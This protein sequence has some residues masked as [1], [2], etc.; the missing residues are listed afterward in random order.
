MPSRDTLHA[1]MTVEQL[2]Q[3]VPGGSGTYIRRLADALVES[4]NV[5]LTGLCARRGRGAARE[6][7]RVEIATSR[8]PRPLLYEG[9]SR[10][11]WP[12]VPRTATMHATGR[13]YDVIH[14]TT[15]AVPPRSAPL[16]VT[17]HDLAFLRTPGHFT[18]RG[19][20]F[21]HRALATVRAE[22]DVVIVPSE[23]T[24][25][26]CLEAGLLP[27]RIHLIHHGTSPRTHDAPDTSAFREAN[28]L[29]RNF[30]LWCGTLEPRKNVP[31]LLRAFEQM[32]A[33]GSDLDLV[34]V[35]PQG[36]GDTSNDVAA[37]LS[38][39]PSDRLHVL[40]R[41]SDEDLQA[42]YAAARVFCFP[43]SWEGFGLPVLEAMTHGTPVVTSRGTSMAEISGDGAL[44][45]DP[46][47]V[48][49]LADALVRAAGKDHER[50]ATAARTN[51]A[52]YTWQRSAELHI[53]AYRAAIKNAATRSVVAR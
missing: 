6:L 47:S 40:G 2:W 12:K 37:A 31:T 26:D 50:L 9:W 1:A 10:L 24:R 11:R 14:A 27:E 38:R 18:P 41:L 39:L 23:A 51:A 21:F 22:A 15:W 16:V 17:V 34:L 45:V 13:G 48:E 5:T 35:G 33:H 43:S 8:L 44:L 20:A 52:H 4:D 53:L 42:A 29:T 3:Q 30:I 19:V 32:L 28:G 46:L 25:Q 36:W 49:D 7:S